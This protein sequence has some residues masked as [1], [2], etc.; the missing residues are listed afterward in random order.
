[1]LHDGA[2]RPIARL[3][4][5]SADRAQGFPQEL[6]K[7]E[8]KMGSR[9]TLATA[10]TLLASVGAAATPSPAPTPYP[11]E[12]PLL[13]GRAPDDAPLPVVDGVA[14]PAPAPTPVSRVTRRL[15][16][17]KLDL[18][19]YARFG[20]DPFA[21]AAA[22]LPAFSETV[23]VFAKPMDTQALTAKMKWWMDD[24]EPIYAGTGPAR[25]HAPTLAEM[26][27][28]RPSPPQ[29][30]DLSTLLGILIGHIKSDDKKSR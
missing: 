4:R 25:F 10:F 19:T 27:E 30:A 11:N 15:L 12:T 9:V 26:R 17:R 21:D 3:V 6:W 14:G 2:F 7:T 24:F 1:L 16:N 18:P 8:V 29:S 22:Q 28:Y 13:G 23:Q 20:T 5:R